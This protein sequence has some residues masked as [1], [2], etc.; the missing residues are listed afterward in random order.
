MATKTSFAYTARFPIFRDRIA[1]IIYV[2]ST[3]SGC[4]HPVP[5]RCMW[6]TGASMSAVSPQVA[7]MLR[8]QVSNERVQLRSGLGG[9]AE[10]E[11]RVAYIHLVLGAIPLRLKVAVVDKPCSD[12]DIDVVLGLDLIMQGSFAL[13]Y[14]G[15]QLMFSFCYPPA[16]IPI[17]FRDLLQH[18]GFD[19]AVV[20]WDGADNDEPDIS[21]DEAANGLKTK[22]NEFIDG[23]E[24]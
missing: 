23:C 2:S 7:Q 22:F 12:P 21:S 9:R 13:S 3:R 16:P 5:F 15:A 19:P 8:L 14:D 20:E 4:L 6:N 10:A 24:K 17:D 18:L 1:S 11:V